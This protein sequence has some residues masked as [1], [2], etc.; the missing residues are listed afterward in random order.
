MATV[1]RWHCV[2]VTVA[3]G[4]VVGVGVG[5]GVVVGVL[6]CIAVGVTDG[7]RVGDVDGV[8]VRV[9]V[10]VGDRVLER[11]VVWA[12]NVWS[13]DGPVPPDGVLP[14]AYSQFSLMAG[15]RW[16]SPSTRG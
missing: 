6:V 16:A 11:V 7:V 1:T 2:G 14:V 13:Y 3:D 10:R 9:V 4:V 12:P 8:A 15:V 5:D